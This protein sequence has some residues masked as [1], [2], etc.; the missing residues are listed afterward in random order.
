MS[1]ATKFRLDTP[2]DWKLAMQRRIASQGQSRYQ[3]ICEAVAKGLCARHSA[4]CLLADPD[5]VTGQRVP[6]LQTAIELAR[7]AGMDLVLVTRGDA[8][9]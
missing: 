1:K 7:A 3:F 4:E 6:S 8:V 5:T 2:M 9:G